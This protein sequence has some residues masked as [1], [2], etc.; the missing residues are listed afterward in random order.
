[1]VA[2]SRDQYRACVQAE[3]ALSAGFGF[4]DYRAVR[5]AGRRQRCGFLEAGQRGALGGTGATRCDAGTGG[6]SRSCRPRLTDSVT[7]AELTQGRCTR[8]W[9]SESEATIVGFHEQERS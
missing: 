2:A 7:R 6:E 3:A 8:T 9:E 1:M 4:D 5:N